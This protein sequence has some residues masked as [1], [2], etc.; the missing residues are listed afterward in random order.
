MSRI[1]LG[2]AQLGMAY[3]IA[4]TTGRPKAAVAL[5]IVAECWQSGVRYFDTAQTYGDSEV[6]LGRA[7]RNVGV[8]SEARVI[9]KL[10]PK[11]KVESVESIINSVQLSVDR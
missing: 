3:G 11:L 5:E 8:A 7:L 1:A 9:S 10:S 6:V 2:T 4:N